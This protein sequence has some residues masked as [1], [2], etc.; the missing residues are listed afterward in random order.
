[1]VLACWTARM[2]DVKTHSQSDEEATVPERELEIVF[3]FAGRIG[4]CRCPDVRLLFHDLTSDLLLRRGT[5]IEKMQHE[6]RR[7]PSA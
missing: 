7:R 4:D 2:G 6:T 3:F 1:V 5:W